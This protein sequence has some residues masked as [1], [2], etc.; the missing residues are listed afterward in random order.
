L[1]NVQVEARLIDDLLDMSRIAHGKLELVREPL[2]LHET[3]RH[4][5]QVALP[6]FEAKAQ[7][8]ALRLSAR[9]HELEGDDT[10]LQQVFWNLLKNASKFTPHKGRISIRTKSNGTVLT[11]TVS[12]GGIGIEPDAL[13]RIFDPFAQADRA[14]TR[15][16]GG[17]GL[18]LAISK[19]AVETHGGTLRAESDGPGQGATFI[20]TLPLR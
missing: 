18:G 15:K 5:V 10:R 19:A 11:V 14:I 2:D 17:L 6:D 1:R 20:V 16:Y 12:D 13:S 8:V 7:P 3:I 9:R 4:A